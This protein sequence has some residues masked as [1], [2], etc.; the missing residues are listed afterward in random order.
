MHKYDKAC[1]TPNAGKNSRE[2]E[3]R[4]SQKHFDDFWRLILWASTMPGSADDLMAAKMRKLAEQ[5]VQASASKC[6]QVQAI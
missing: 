5:K 2:T 3:N 4:E 6:K 1:T